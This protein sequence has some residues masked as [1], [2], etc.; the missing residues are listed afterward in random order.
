MDLIPYSQEATYQDFLDQAPHIGQVFLIFPCRQPVPPNH[1]V[2]LLLC[3]LLCL[4]K[5]HHTQDEVVQS[6]TSCLRA[7]FYET[8]AS[9]RSSQVINSVFL[10]IV[11]IKGLCEAIWSLATVCF[12]LEPIPEIKINSAVMIEYS[13]TD[14]APV[15]Q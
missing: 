12:P 11:E 14:G 9:V 5:Q 15:A 6:C 8:S 13:F 3:L 10:R 4:G 7:S 1:P 2:E